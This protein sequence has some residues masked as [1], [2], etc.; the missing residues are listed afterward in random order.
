MVAETNAQSRERGDRTR[1]SWI[2]RLRAIDL[3]SPR[4]ANKLGYILLTPAV[5]RIPLGLEIQFNEFAKIVRTE[6]QR[7]VIEDLDPAEVAARL[8]EQAEAL[9]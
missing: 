6:M 4:H 1:T 8:Q 2:D 3:S 9:Q 7:M 5:Y